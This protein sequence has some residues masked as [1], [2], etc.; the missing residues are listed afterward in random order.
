MEGLRAEGS[1][2]IARVRAALGQFKQFRGPVVAP[3]MLRLLVG[4]VDDEVGNGHARHQAVSGGML[5]SSK[6]TKTC[7]SSITVCQRICRLMSKYACTR[8][9]RMPIMSSQGISGMLARVSF[10]S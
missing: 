8:R 4:G 7:R 3:V 9:W 2:H 10:E 1:H 5:D 6:R